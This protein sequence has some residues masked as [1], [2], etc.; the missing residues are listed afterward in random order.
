ME[1]ELHLRPE[2]IISIHALRE[3]GDLLRLANCA[4]VR[5]F[6]STPS[7]RRATADSDGCYTII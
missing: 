4:A 5:P 3:E 6:L 2:V 7:A 1:V